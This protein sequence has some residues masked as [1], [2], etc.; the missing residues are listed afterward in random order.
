MAEETKGFKVWNVQMQEIP[1]DAKGEDGTAESGQKAIA[2]VSVECLQCGET[3][4]ATEGAAE[5]SL[6]NVLGG[7][8]ISC[9]SCKQTGGVQ[10][11]DFQ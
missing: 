7:I 9:P 8:V 11:P 4:T 5:K 6:T 3:W 1:S 10:R 2:S